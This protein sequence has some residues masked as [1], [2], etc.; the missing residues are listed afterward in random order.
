[1]TIEEVKAILKSN[2]ENESDRE[3]WQEKLE[4]LEEKQRTA[5]E[6]QKYYSEMIKYER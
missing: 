2:F 3:Y 5:K 6:N 1:M 4:E